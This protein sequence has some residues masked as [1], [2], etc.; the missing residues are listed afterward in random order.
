MGCT[1]IDPDAPTVSW[2][3]DGEAP[4]AVVVQTATGESWDYSVRMAWRAGDQEGV[5]TETVPTGSA[6]TTIELPLSLDAALVAAAGAMPVEIDLRLETLSAT[7]ERVDTF[8]GAPLLVWVDALGN[9]ADAWLTAEV[10]DQGGLDPLT[11]EVGPTTPFLGPDGQP[12]LI[13]NILGEEN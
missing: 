2:S 4:L 9:L 5:W 8:V 12:L 10:I 7:G 6:G 1:P 13:T 3:L 11:G